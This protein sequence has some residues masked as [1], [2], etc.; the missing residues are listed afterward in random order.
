LNL[1]GRK[2]FMCIEG[3]EWEKMGKKAA[4]KM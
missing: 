2:L 3:E 1:I 4:F